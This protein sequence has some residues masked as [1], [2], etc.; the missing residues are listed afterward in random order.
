MK[1]HLRI[2]APVYVVFTFIVACGGGSDEPLPVTAI[3]KV[4]NE[5][6]CAFNRLDDAMNKCKSGVGDILPLLLSQQNGGGNSGTQTALLLQMMNKPK[7]KQ[8]AP[9]LPNGDNC[10]QPQVDNETSCKDDMVTAF[11]LLKSSHLSDGSMAIND[12]IVR[13]RLEDVIKKFIAVASM[14][15][16]LNPM[17]QMHLGLSLNNALNSGALNGALAAGDLSILNSY[18][19][20]PQMRALASPTPAAAPNGWP[21]STPGIGTNTNTAYSTPG[22]PVSTGA[23]GSSTR[24]TLGIGSGTNTASRS[25]VTDDTPKSPVVQQTV[26]N[27]SLMRAKGYGLPRR[28]VAPKL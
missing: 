17:Q 16:Q 9:A 20:T 8:P 14:Q 4:T 15:F 28:A 2:L 19:N 21:V 12:P 10:P 23:A 3:P 22:V 11:L 24:L 18:L 5:V 7:R 27:T 13:K 26:S 1:R 6:K 25:L